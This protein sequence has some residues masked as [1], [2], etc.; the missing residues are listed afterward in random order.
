[1]RQVDVAPVPLE[2]MAQA[3][4]P[5]RGERLIETARRTSQMM[6]GRT[7]WNLS[8]TSQGGGVAEML[9][10]LVAY[11]RAAGLDIGG[12]YWAGIRSSSP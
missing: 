4:S 6:E 11:G 7:V 9:Q 8:S 10:T 2:R 3:L 12:W 5:D 1:M